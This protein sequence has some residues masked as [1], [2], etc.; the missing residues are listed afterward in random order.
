MPFPPQGQPDRRDPY[1]DHQPVLVHPL[2]WWLGARL[3]EERERACDESV[4]DAGNDP[5][6]YA[7]AS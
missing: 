4:L 2:L 6:I 1:A 3:V 5:A 7:T